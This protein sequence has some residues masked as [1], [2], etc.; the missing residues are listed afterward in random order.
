MKVL[1]RNV[2][3]AQHS[4]SHWISDKVRF[5]YQ[6]LHFTLSTTC[7][8]SISARSNQRAC[9][10]IFAISSRNLPVCFRR[11]TELQG[12]TF[13]SFHGKL[14]T[15]GVRSINH[16]LTQRCFPNFCPI[17]IYEKRKH[18]MVVHQRCASKVASTVAIKA[19]RSF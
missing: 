16:C 8:F 12:I 6:R 11:S 1:R 7:F 14:A 18:R 4:T 19:D 13:Y 5:G 2:I 9:V 10:A 17:P 15:Y 3:L